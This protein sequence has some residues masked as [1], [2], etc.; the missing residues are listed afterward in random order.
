MQFITLKIILKRLSCNE[1]QKKWKG[2]GNWKR[3]ETN[4]G[5][6]LLP[7]IPSFEFQFWKTNFTLLKWNEIFHGDQT[8]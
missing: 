1:F 3:A 4:L 2:G 5:S 6:F 7:Q 8:N